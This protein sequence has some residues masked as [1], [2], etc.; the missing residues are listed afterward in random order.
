MVSKD[1]FKRIA[2]ITEENAEFEFSQ[3]KECQSQKFNKLRDERNKQPSALNTAGAHDA[4]RKWFLHLSTQKLTQHQQRA[5]EHGFNYATVPNKIPKEDIIAGVEVAL[6][7]TKEGTASGTTRKSTRKSKSGN[8]KHPSDSET[9][10]DKLY[11]GR[12]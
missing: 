4:R 12:T 5:L 8:S 11:K 2:K 6:T 3:T 9:S 7:E 1:D 10:A